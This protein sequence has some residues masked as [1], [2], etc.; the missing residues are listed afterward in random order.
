MRKS[1]RKR[2]RRR[3]TRRGRGKKGKKGKHSGK[4]ADRA[5]IYLRNA[6]GPE[7]LAVVREHPLRQIIS[8]ENNFNNIG[9]VESEGEFP[10]TTNGELSVEKTIEE[11]IPP[12]EDMG[13][14]INSDENSDMSDEGAQN[15]DYYFAPNME[16]V[17][18]ETFE[19][20]S[21]SEK[22]RREIADMNDVASGRDARRAKR[23][24]QRD[25]AR[26]TALAAMVRP[27]SP[28]LR[29]I[30]MGDPQTRA[31][32][33]AEGDEWW[34]RGLADRL[35]G[36]EGRTAVTPPPPGSWGD[37]NEEEK[38]KEFKES[39]KAQKQRETARRYDEEDLKRAEKA[40]AAA[41][42]DPKVGAAA[43][44]AADEWDDANIFEFEQ[45]GGRRKRR[46][47]R[48]RTRKKKA[49]YGPITTGGW[50][51]HNLLLPSQH[52]GSLGMWWT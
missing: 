48:R 16:A 8:E 5:P 41:A 52:L 46:R 39:W 25:K 15:N 14:I 36:K 50:I 35:G 51:P 7:L 21:K 45:G 2:P 38:E 34:K 31:S 6:T 29:E 10:D 24:R 23:D 26:R 42:N 40:A 47:R 33:E 32:L 27:V 30:E 4:K 43:N 17:G 20:L 13:R 18:D 28:W 3:R 12:L 49:G 22:L 1:R 19:E 37:D 11:Q 44:A 9:L